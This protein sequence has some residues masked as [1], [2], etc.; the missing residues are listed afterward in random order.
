MPRSQMHPGYATLELV[1][2]VIKVLGQTIYGNAVQYV[3]A[4]RPV[5]T[6]F[7]SHVTAFTV[8]S[9]HALL[10]ATHHQTSAKLI[11]LHLHSYKFNTK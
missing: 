11:K 7:I 3:C 10:D 4:Q 6:A 5:H 2:G 8:T 1:T 9:G